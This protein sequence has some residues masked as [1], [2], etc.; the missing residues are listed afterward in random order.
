MAMHTSCPRYHRTRQNFTK[1]FQQ[2]VKSIQCT[3]CMHPVI[4]HSELA[5]RGIVIQHTIYIHTLSTTGP[6]QNNK[7]ADVVITEQN[8]WMQITNLL[9]SSFFWAA[10]WRECCQ[11]QALNGTRNGGQVT[12]DCLW[13]CIA[14]GL[15]CSNEFS[16]MNIKSKRCHFLLQGETK[17]RTQP[18]FFYVTFSEL[19]I[20]KN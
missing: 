13:H 1:K 14:F 16:I 3:G 4:I 18:Y 17:W 5:T 20:N 2:V 7:W 19:R 15:F 11:P 6:F 9:S 10:F 8:S 12:P